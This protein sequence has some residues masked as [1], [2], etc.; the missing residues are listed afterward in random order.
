M[1]KSKFR[2]ATIRTIINYHF[3]D[4]DSPRYRVFIIMTNSSR[5]T[6]PSTSRGAWIERAAEHLYKRYRLT[7]EDVGESESDFYMRWHDQG[8]SPEDAVDAFGAK[9]DLQ[10][11]ERW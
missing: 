2:S 5:N 11:A 1:V 8:E 6:R 9:Y 4:S 3:I 7:L 10:G